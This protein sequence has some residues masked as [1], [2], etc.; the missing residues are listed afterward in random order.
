[1]RDGTPLPNPQI[2]KVLH[3]NIVNIFT[4]KKVRNLTCN[5]AILKYIQ[6]AKDYSRRENMNCLITSKEISLLTIKKNLPTK[7]SLIQSDFTSAFN[8]IFKKKIITILYKCFHIKNKRREHFST[9]S[10]KSVLF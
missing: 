8:Q 9:H 3:G 10:M 5:G 7:L 6:I 4:P 2:S 1:M